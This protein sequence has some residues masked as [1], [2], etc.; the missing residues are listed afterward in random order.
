MILPSHIVIATHMCIAV[1][2]RTNRHRAVTD[3]QTS[4]LLL[5][6]GATW[7][8]PI[9]HHSVEPNQDSF[10]FLG[11]LL[12]WKMS[13]TPVKSVSQSLP[14]WHPGLFSGRHCLLCHHLR[15][16]QVSTISDSVTL[17]SLSELCILAIITV[18]CSHSR[19]QIIKLTPEQENTL[20]RFSESY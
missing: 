15:L 12:M 7:N 13:L 11:F 3:S 8:I 4:S 2:V 16:L 1:L 18:R 6:W 14:V 17:L 9:M 19:S 10:L 20:T 5:V